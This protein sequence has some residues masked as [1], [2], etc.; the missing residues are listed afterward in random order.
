MLMFFY[1]PIFFFLFFFYLND[2]QLMQHKIRVLFSFNCSYNYEYMQ[3]RT[4]LHKQAHL[5]A[6]FACFVM[7][8]SFQME[9]IK[10]FLCKYE[11]VCV[12]VYLCKFVCEY[13]CFDYLKIL[14]SANIRF[15]AFSYFSF[16]THTRNGK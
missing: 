13:Y 2:F 6:K 10:S 16:L 4:L 11:C 12:C 3:Q 8:T 9:R 15:H 5:N 1:F 14:M 7:Y